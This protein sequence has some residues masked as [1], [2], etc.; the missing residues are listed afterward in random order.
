MVISSMEFLFASGNDDGKNESECD[1]FV[2]LFCFDLFDVNAIV[3]CQMGM[4]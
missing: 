1:C 2:C 3:K 4:H